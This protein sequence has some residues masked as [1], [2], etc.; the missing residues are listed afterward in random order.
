MKDIKFIEVNEEIKREWMNYSNWTDKVNDEVIRISDGWSIIAEK[1]TEMMGIISVYYRKMDEPFE[2]TVEAYID[3]IEV[4]EPFRTKG[5]ASQLIKEAI[6]R[7]EKDVTIYQIRSWSS[8]DKTA[9]LKLW[10]K[11]GFGLCPVLQH[12]G[13]VKVPGFFVSKVLYN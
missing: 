1:N 3:N 5:V 9:M 7:V 13:D 4:L 8:K 12:Y 2:N 11:M 10:K 6:S